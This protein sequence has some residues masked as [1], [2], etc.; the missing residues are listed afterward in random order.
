MRLG[1]MVLCVSVERLN[2]LLS[3]RNKQIATENVSDK[4]R[5]F[6]SGWTYQWNSAFHQM[7]L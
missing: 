3:L 4:M 5:Q 7:L 6:L 2:E 1:N